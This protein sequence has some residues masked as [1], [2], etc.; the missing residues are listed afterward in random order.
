MLL[1]GLVGLWL[2]VLFELCCCPVVL[3]ARLYTPQL[4]FTAVY[5][6]VD[7][8]CCAWRSG[9]TSRKCLTTRSSHLCVQ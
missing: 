5:I 6:I 7:G 8:S 1:V 4:P 3:E 9:V 2:N